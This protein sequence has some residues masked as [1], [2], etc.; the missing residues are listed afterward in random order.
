MELTEINNKQF[1]I[2]E[3]FAHSFLVLSDV[4]K[5][6]CKVTTSTINVMKVILPEMTLRSALNS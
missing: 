3:S 5:F 4:A 2:R 1:Y 6:C